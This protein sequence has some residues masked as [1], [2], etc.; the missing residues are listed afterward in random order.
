MWNKK[1]NFFNEH[2]SQVPV[3]DEYQNFYRLYYSTRIDGKSNPMFIDVDK[4]DPSKILNKSEKPILKLGNRGSFDWAGV[5]PTEII[6]L[7]D[8]KFL[9]YIGWSLRMDVP[10]HN[11]LG[12][13]ISRD[14]GNTWKKIS[15]GPVLSTSYLE[16]GYVGTVSIL[17]ENGVWRMW[18]LSCLNWVESEVGLEP[19]YDI[20][21][22][23]SK[24]G[25]NWV[26]IGITCIP[27]TNDEGGISSQRVI[28]INDKYHM[29]YS[30]RNK[31]DYR[32]NIKNSYRIK[33]S[34]SND[35]LSW[36]KEDDVELDIDLNSSWDNIMVCYPFIVQKE[37]KLI[38]FY[39]GNEFGKTGIGYAV[40]ESIE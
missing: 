37:N 40:K 32:K 12:L 31:T 3:G 28:K 17:I 7:G 21:Y 16:P 15:D 13:A 18:Y 10:Y 22:A 8:T 23:E 30:V 29:W 38:M 26:P 1:G 4:E 19:T 20:K 9:Y 33:K 39:N 36:I 24:D 35:G 14:N 25:I 2:H 11:N 5:M 6:T 27:L 34:T